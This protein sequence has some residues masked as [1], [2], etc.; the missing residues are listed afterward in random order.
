MYKLLPILFVLGCTSA[1]PR[2][3]DSAVS[4]Q[5][6]KSC[7][8]GQQEP[9]YF[10]GDDYPKRN[11]TVLGDVF[12]KATR[13]AVARKEVN[14]LARLHCADAIVKVEEISEGLNDIVKGS[15]VKFN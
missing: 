1:P 3:I 9:A 8:P 6:K 4:I 15:L 7:R 14:R 2:L 13:N 5:E 11:F 10:S 12:A